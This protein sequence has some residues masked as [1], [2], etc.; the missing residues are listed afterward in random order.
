M[1]KHQASSN[2]LKPE[3]VEKHVSRRITC[4]DPLGLEF[5][6]QAIGPATRGC[7]NIHGHATSGVE[8]FLKEM[9]QVF[10]AKNSGQDVPEKK[11]NHYQQVYNTGFTYLTFWIVQL[12]IWYQNKSPEFQNAGVRVGQNGR[13]KNVS[14]KLFCMISYISLSVIS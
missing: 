3:D 2:L 9:T 4:D 12:H 13:C 10:R 6:G 5:R 7:T 1:K 11:T 14:S 8:L